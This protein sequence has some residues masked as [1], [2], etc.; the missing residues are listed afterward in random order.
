MK[1]IETH[2]LFTNLSAI[3]FGKMRLHCHA[4]VLTKNGVNGHTLR[5][6][7]TEACTEIFDV[8]F[9]EARDYE[10]E[11][12]TPVQFI[13]DE[14]FHKNG[15]RPYGSYKLTVG[16]L[17]LTLHTEESE[18]EIDVQEFSGDE[19]SQVILDVWKLLA[20]KTEHYWT[21]PAMPMSVPI[22]PADRLSMQRQLMP[23]L[24]R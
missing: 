7:E 17:E 8:H 2:T 5:G 22:P 23:G 18:F 4:L 9:K 12:S 13:E 11:D 16:D 21:A 19:N 1:K 10:L 3:E 20:R 6:F 15:H 24:H 14:F